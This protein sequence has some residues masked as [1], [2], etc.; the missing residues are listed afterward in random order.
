M[1]LE[2]C[3]PVSNPPCNSSGGRRQSP[4]PAV[5]VNYNLRS[6][7]IICTLALVLSS[8]GLAAATKP[9]APPKKGATAKTAA[10][11]KS[12]AKK[13]YNKKGPIKAASKSAASRH[14]STTR[15]GTKAGVHPKAAVTA[16]SRTSSP[17]RQQTPTTE[18]YS[19]I[20]KALVDKGYFKGE[21]NGVWG[22]GSVDAL[23]RFQTAN[24]LTPDGKIGAR[25]L[26]GLGLGPK[27]ESAGEIAVTPK[28]AEEGKQ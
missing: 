4:A 2:R 5:T 14:P 22:A 26:I 25:S 18:R 16:R 27:H 8:L 13:S 24:Q 12:S 21:P 9:A 10:A 23:K 19:E 6:F 17:P 1:F 3:P 20:Q 28:A 7:Q 15:A 11:K